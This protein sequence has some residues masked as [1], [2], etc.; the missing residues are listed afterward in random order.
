M[1]GK[2]SLV[3]RRPVLA[4][5]PRSM[6]LVVERCPGWMGFLRTKVLGGEFVLGMVEGDMG[7]GESEGLYGGIWVWVIESG[8][9]VFFGIY[10]YWRSYM[11]VNMQDN[12][13]GQ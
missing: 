3:F 6:R 12:S 9:I 1:V 8:K 10:N 7:C 13:F 2:R 4:R 5:S 11:E